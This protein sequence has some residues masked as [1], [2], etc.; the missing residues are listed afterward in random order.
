MGFRLLVDGLHDELHGAGWHDVRPA[1]GFVLLACRDQ[2]TSA[3]EIAALMGT[4]KQAASKL[5]E[6]MEEIGYVTRSASAMDGR[7]KAVELSAR[8]RELLGVVEQSYRTLETQWAT[9]IGR[10]RWSACEPICCAYSS[11]P[12]TTPSSGAPTLAALRQ[13]TPTLA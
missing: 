13:T 3:K 11:T 2:P 12:T 8:G 10:S 9:V 6:S 1:F 5:I 7:G 4:T